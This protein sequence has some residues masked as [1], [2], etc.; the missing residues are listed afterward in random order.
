MSVAK[1]IGVGALLGFLGLCGR[2]APGYDGGPA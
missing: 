1:T 2:P